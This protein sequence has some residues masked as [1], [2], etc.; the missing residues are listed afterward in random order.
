VAQPYRVYLITLPGRDIVNCL[1]VPDEYRQRKDGR[2]G[3][4]AKLEAS[5]LAEGFRN[6]VL[7]VAGMVPPVFDRFLS[8][9]WRANPTDI[10]ACVKLGGS[11]LWVAQQHDLAV[12]CVVSDFCGR[13]A[14]QGHPELATPDAVMAT[15]RDPPR[16]VTFGPQGIAT[17]QLQHTHLTEASGG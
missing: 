7:V 11:R 17:S 1:S 10:L 6:P 8:P 16:W 2:N 3:F 15:F 5:V 9:E 12:P 4:Y 13:F 14:G